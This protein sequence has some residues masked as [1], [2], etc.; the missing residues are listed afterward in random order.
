MEAIGGT[1]KD[2]I[3]RQSATPTPPRVII[4]LARD[5]REAE[6]RDAEI[7]VALAASMA[8]VACARGFLVAVEADW[9]DLSTPLGG[10]A[11]HAA[12]CLRE[13]GMLDLSQTRTP[14]GSTQFRRG[15]SGRILVTAGHAGAD[16]DRHNA[17]V[18]SAGAPSA[19][20]A[21]GAALPDILLGDPDTNKRR[22]RARGGSHASRSTRPNTPVRGAA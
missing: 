19:W 11:F 3:V 10:G 9:A 22:R 2:L 17:L 13:L 12:R 20:L 7:A 15:M 16:P 6:E 14:T 8:A 21:G 5:V 18:L 4:T 1:R